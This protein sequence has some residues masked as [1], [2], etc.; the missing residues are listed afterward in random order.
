[1]KN[2]KFYLSLIS[3]ILLISSTSCN[4]AIDNNGS[5]N[6][7][8]SLLNETDLNIDLMG[9][10]ELGQNNTKPKSRLN[11]Q[12]KQVDESFKE[13]DY[14]VHYVKDE[15]DY[16]IYSSVLSV[17][18]TL[19][20]Y[21]NQ[22][23]ALAEKIKENATELGEFKDGDIKY[24]L[25]LQNKNKGV[26]SFTDNTK[27][28]LN[29]SIY[30]SEKG[31]W[32]TCALASWESTYC[33]LQ[34]K[35]NQFTIYK[36]AQNVTLI[37][38]NQDPLVTKEYF[39]EY[40]HVKKDNNGGYKSV[41]AIIH[42]ANNYDASRYYFNM[43]KENDT[44]Y[45]ID[46]TEYPSSN[47]ID[48][49]FVSFIDS[50]VISYNVRTHLNGD[51]SDINENSISYKFLQN[52]KQY[53]WTLQVSSS[54]CDGLKVFPEFA[55]DALSAKTVK[56]IEKVYYT[57]DWFNTYLDP[58]YVPSNPAP[59]WLPSFIGLPMRAI[60]TDKGIYEAVQDEI[61]YLDSLGIA[62]NEG[63]I[64]PGRGE[65]A[66]LYLDE[67]SSLKQYD[68][69]SSKVDALGLSLND[70]FD[71]NFT[72]F[73]KKYSRIDLFTPS[74][75][76]ELIDYDNVKEFLGKLITNNQEV[77]EPSNFIKENNKED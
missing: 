10:F 7:F 46:S 3:T 54:T 4:F 41:R 73:L 38:A 47:S 42:Q 43:Y 23:S 44:T 36:K 51:I 58:S 24:T 53:F 13:E 8:K 71:P 62:D 69:W 50:L 55:S 37:D 2:T 16:N 15:R 20:P 77:F 26:I 22:M 52:R 1:M 29:S 30:N 68:F 61:C 9:G 45:Y 40:I 17:Q 19:I 49:S 60:K 34:F 65:I 33:E 48:T 28:D 57:K 67:E 12:G 74:F 31:K 35:K 18:N 75:M 21:V 14:E 6:D 59:E 25:S 56:Q 70:E 76:K 66:S 5:F 63:N 72:S 64:R 32:E 27:K 11:A 39:D